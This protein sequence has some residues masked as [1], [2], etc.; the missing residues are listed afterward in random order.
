MRSILDAHV[1]EPGLA[2]VEIAAADD[3]TAFAIQQLLA[4]HCATARA[5]RTTR[6]PG[7]SGVRLRCFI[8]LRQESDS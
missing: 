1:A 2:V 6:D 8:D 7:G 3:A 5:D 4:E